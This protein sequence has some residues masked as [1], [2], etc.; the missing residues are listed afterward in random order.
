MKNS[1]LLQLSDFSLGDEGCRVLSDFL[2]SHSHEHITRLD[3]KANN[4]GERGITYLAQVLSDNDSIKKL[5]LEW[6]N[7]GLSDSGV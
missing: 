6:N 1:P 5:S 3:L 2:R 4:I 7:I